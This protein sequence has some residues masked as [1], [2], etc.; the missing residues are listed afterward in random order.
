M[1]ESTVQSRISLRISAAVARGLRE[2]GAIALGGLALVICVALLSFDPHDPGF[3]YTGVGASVHNRIGPVG[4]WFADALFFLFGRPAYLL[5]LI[6]A[7]AAWRL[8][9]ASSDAAGGSRL[10][11]AVRVAGFIGL[12]VSSCALTALHWNPGDL[13]QGAGGV[14]G[15]AAGGALASGLKLL[16]ATLLLLVT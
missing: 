11:L 14:V 8:M 5:P 10:N 4:A 7:V 16:G 15:S 13:P 6:L 12:L 2:S 3:S 9:R 1:A